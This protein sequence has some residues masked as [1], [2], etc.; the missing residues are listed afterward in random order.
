MPEDQDSISKPK[1]PKSDDRIVQQRPHPDKPKKAEEKES[2][3][4]KD[5]KEVR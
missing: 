1:K 4:K 5:K 3:G 2:E